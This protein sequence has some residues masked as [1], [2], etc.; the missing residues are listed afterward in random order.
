VTFDG[1]RN[2]DF[3]PY[4][5][6]TSDYG[7]SWKSISNNLPEG[8]TVNV[9]REHHRNPDLLFIGTE[10][11][12][13]VSIDRGQKWVRIKGNLPLVPVDD[14]AIHPREN[15]L[16]FG[17]H[18]RSIWVLDDIT[19]LEQLSK[20]VLASQGY[21]H[22]I[23]E[24][25][26]F[27]PYN[28]KGSLG[29]K[30]FVGSNPPPGA[31]ISYYLK[32]E[33][34]EDVKIIIE[35]KDG[36]KIREIKGTKEGGINRITW[37]LRYE[38]PVQLFRGERS[39]WFRIQAPYVLP[40]EYQVALKVSDQVMAKTVEVIGDPRIDISFEDRKAHHDALF[41]LYE[42][43]PILSEVDK[44]SDGLKK[45]L[46]ELTE[47]LKK[48]PDVPEI[49]LEEVKAISKEIDDIRLK[50]LGDPKLGWRGLRRSLRGRIVMLGRAVGRYTSS[51]SPRQLQQIQKNSEQLK[52]LVE[53]LNKV[54]DEAI[55][56][57]NKLMNKN[58]IPHLIP[59]EK[60]EIRE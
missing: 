53:R 45:Q 40:G 2:D 20:D 19:P 43:Y 8:G 9:I 18:G 57:L 37:D 15:D 55:P 52:A 5:F 50:L 28:H 48:L 59:G 17:T 60:I 23:R 25:T 7:E 51:P 3:K 39:R 16:I 36:K 26:I 46:D 49:I 22:N 14:I 13:Y 35:D 33:I 10:R 1:H 21:L 54:I 34:K 12:A 38:P 4:V 6:V 31:I 27:N 56:R 30:V 47:S 42:L 24:A 44:V 29:H 41:T 11:G 32:E 58:N